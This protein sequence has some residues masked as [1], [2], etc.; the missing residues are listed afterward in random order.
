MENYFRSVGKIFAAVG[1]TKPRL[2]TVGSLDFSL[3]LKLKAYAR[4]DPPPIRVQPIP[5]EI[6]HCLNLTAQGG[7]SRQHSI[8][9]LV[10]IA[11]F[12][13][14]L[15]GEHFQGGSGSVFFSF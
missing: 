12:F 1:T 15:P 8:K 10:W 11:F 4:Q 2:N 5:I 7:F 6:F 13:L 3:L 14:L 9:D